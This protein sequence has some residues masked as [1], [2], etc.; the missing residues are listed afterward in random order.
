MISGTFG[1]R[2]SVS[3]ERYTPEGCKL[4][5]R[6]L[7][8]ALV[9]VGRAVGPYLNAGDRLESSSKPSRYLMLHVPVNPVT[10]FGHRRLHVDLPADG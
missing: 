3:Q 7:A 1:T 8:V 9:H 4:L 10:F 5:Y 2:N 6:A